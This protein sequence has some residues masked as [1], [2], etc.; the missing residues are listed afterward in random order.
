MARLEQMAHLEQTVPTEQNFLKNLVLARMV[1]PQ[2]TQ[3]LR[4]QTGQP[5]LL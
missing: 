3:F 1:L 5:C 4:L 2:T